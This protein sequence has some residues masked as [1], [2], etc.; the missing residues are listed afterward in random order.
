MLNDKWIFTCRVVLFQSSYHS[1]RFQTTRHHPLVHTLMS[2]VGVL[3]NNSRASAHSAR[4]R[5]GVSCLITHWRKTPLPLSLR[6]GPA[7]WADRRRTA[8]VY[9]CSAGRSPPALSAHRLLW[10]IK[11]TKLHGSKKRSLVCNPAVESQHCGD[12]SDG[13]TS[14]WRLQGDLTWILLVCWNPT[15]WM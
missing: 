14:E 7:L 13:V 9:D 2:T 11:L 5:F 6:Y 15:T 1:K 4:E 8:G 3:T 12:L 10:N